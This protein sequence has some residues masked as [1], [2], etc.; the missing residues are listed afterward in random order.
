[1]KAM[2]E[3]AGRRRGPQGALRTAEDFPVILLQLL[4]VMLS[5]LVLGAHFL[6]GGNVVLVVLVLVGIGLL[7]LRR[8]WVARLVQAA[9]VLGALEWVRSLVQL[10][11]QRMQ[12]GQPA[13]RLVLILGSVALFTLLSALMFRTTRLR[14]RFGLGRSA[15]D[16]GLGAPADGGA[17]LRDE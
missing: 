2:A 10:T 17:E 12:E 11:G 9:L 15:E 4:P 6:R 14:L 7:G 5:L 3:S 16:R 13:T 8:P 1:M